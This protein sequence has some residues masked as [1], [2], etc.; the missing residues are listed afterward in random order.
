MVSPNLHLSGE[1]C[2]S[3]TPI[4]SEA[5]EDKDIINKNGVSDK[6]ETEKI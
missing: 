6:E 4:L 3:S 2:E 1:I 5:A